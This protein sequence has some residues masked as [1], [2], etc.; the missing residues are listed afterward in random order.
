MKLLL[1][2]HQ[3]C[4]ISLTEGSELKNHF[5]FSEDAF[6]K[7]N[8]EK[9]RVIKKDRSGKELFPFKLQSK[10]NAYVLNAD[11]YV[12]IDWLVKD[13]KFVQV[14]PKINRAVVKAFLAQAEVSVED[15]KESKD[16][17]SKAK[18]EIKEESSLIEIDYLKILLEI[19][20]NPL[21]T[22]EIP[23]ILTID[24][25]ASQIPIEQKDDR[26]TPFLIVQFLKLLKTIVR[27]GLRK[28]YY[29][30]QEN[31]QN[32]VK[33][34]ILVGQHIKQNVFKNRF[35]QTYCEYQ[36][37]GVDHIENRFLKKV[38]L[39][40]IEYV[41]NDKVLLTAHKDALMEI[42]NYCRPAFEHVSNAI[43]EQEVKNMKYNPFFKEYK[44]A[45]KIGSYILKKFAYNISNTSK[46]QVT[47]PPFW[48]DMPILF[49]LYFY[50][51]LI[52]HNPSQAKC[53]HYQLSTYGNS[54]DILISH[55]DYQMIVDTKYKLQYKHSRVHK[56]IRQVSGYARLN[57]IRKELKLGDDKD[58]IIDC[59]IVYPNLES[60]LDFDFSLENVN[61]SM[62]ESPINDYYK[63]FKLGIS[64]PLIKTESPPSSHTFP[65]CD[66]QP[67]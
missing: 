60:S 7:I 6:T 50:H 28:S 39:F 47:T 35:T 13:E 17:A 12:G 36:E 38:F 29:K 18:D 15:I 30:V 57:K 20:S 58:K 8:P 26:L 33:G 40:A 55:P 64:L 3:S 59:L 16:I 46:N 44:S 37:F 42:I 14:E 23:K 65:T 31:L 66:Q 62:R 10:E 19:S 52:K 24:W 45:V 25:E 32:R 43:K 5:H 63:V 67:I 21:I 56:D 41:Q 61:K 51:Q 1:S 4:R 49:E 9:I 27:K 48:I 22:D 54:L 11:Y 34:K 53:I 2:E